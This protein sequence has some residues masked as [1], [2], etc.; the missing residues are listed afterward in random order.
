MVDFAIAAVS[1]SLP[2]ATAILDLGCGAGDLGRSLR[3]VFSGRLDGVD[4]V[5]FEGFP[6]DLYTSFIASN[7]DDDAGTGDALYDVVFAI[8]VIEHLEN[9]RQFIRAAARR[10]KP[11]GALVVTTVNVLSLTSIATLA[12]Q[13]AFREF[14]DGVGMYP[15]HITPVT[16]LDATRMMREA[17]LRDVSVGFSNDGRLPYVDMPFQRL[18]PLRGRWFSDNFR[19]VGYRAA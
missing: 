3:P 12:V 7:L 2:G 19:A 4:I 14:R 8:E 6:S 15:A 10:L 9:P 5:R 17:D 16:P 1:S 13:G 18:L 11:G